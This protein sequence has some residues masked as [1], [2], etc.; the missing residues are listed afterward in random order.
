MLLIPKQAGTEYIGI[1]QFFQMTA[2]KGAYLLS[3][4]LKKQLEEGKRVLWIVSG[5]SNIP[6]TIEVINELPAK[7]TRRLTM[8]PVDERYGPEGHKDSNIKQLYDA[9]FNPKYAVLFAPLDGSSLDETVR[10]YEKAA[11][12]AFGHT[13]MAI[14]Q[15]GMGTDGH[16]AG[17]LPDS[18]ALKAESLVTAYQ[19][20]DYMRITMTFAAL[21]RI[22]Q[23]Y[24]FAYGRPKRA[25]LDR[26][27]DGDYPIND[28]PA[29]VLRELREVTVYNDQLEDRNA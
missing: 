22:H 2:S 24:L 1:M 20:P 11:A 5:G 13:D 3:L 26:L 17:I 9:G 15:L 8:L 12:I 7:L 27:C 10:N 4:N 6:L 28:Q 16:I 25:A 23:A 29:Q 14:A 19:G 18:P 21:R